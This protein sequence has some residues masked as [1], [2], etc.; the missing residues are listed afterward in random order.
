MKKTSIMATAGSEGSNALK[1]EGLATAHAATGFPNEV[2]L[3]LETIAKEKKVLL[4]WVIAMR[5]RTASPTGG[6][7]SLDRSETRACG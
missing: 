1:T 4:A 6:R 7:Y 3:P 5:E 2:F